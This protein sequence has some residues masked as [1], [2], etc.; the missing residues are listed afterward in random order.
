[1][2]ITDGK[3][4]VHNWSESEPSPLALHHTPV[5]TTFAFLVENGREVVIVDPTEEEELVQD[6][7]ACAALN[8]HGEICSIQFS[9]AGISL[10]ALLRATSLAALRSREM[11]EVIQMAVDEALKEEGNIGKRNLIAYLQAPQQ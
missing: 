10:D 8:G 4:K 1:V 5:C 9:G 6:A 2:T 7:S 3:V 11:I